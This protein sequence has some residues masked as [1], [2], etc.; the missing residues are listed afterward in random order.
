MADVRV[1]PVDLDAAGTELGRIGGDV[2]G[3]ARGKSVV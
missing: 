2:A 3:A 1:H